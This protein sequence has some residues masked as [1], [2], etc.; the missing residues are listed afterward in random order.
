MAAGGVSWSDIL[1]ILSNAGVAGAWVLCW[2]KGWVVSDRELKRADAERDEWKKLYTTEREAHEKTREA[3]H[4]AS[5]RGESTT[6]ALQ[7]VA[8]VMTAVRA[9]ADHNALPE[10]QS[11]RGSGAKAGSRGNRQIHSSG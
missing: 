10:A 6:E 1:P 5:E 8:S 9:Q 7:L 2:L 11:A 3:L 4:V